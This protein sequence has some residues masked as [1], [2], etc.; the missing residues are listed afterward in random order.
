MEVKMLDTQA[1]E[2]ENISSYGRELWDQ[3][4]FL[5]KSTQLRS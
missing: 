5:E 1:S 4:S 2:V 3:V